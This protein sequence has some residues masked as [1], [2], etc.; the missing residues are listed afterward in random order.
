MFTDNYLAAK[1]NYY[2][3]FIQILILILLLLPLYWRSR[4]VS[5]FIKCWKKGKI[6][7]AKFESA[8]HLYDYYRNSIGR[9]LAVYKYQVGE[10]SF[11]LK[12]TYTHAMYIHILNQSP[13]L[14]VPVIVKLTVT[15]ILTSGGYIPGKKISVAVIPNEIKEKGA[16]YVIPLPFGDE[17]QIMYNPDNPKEAIPLCVLDDEIVAALN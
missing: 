14:L 2:L 7:T 16:S 4:S 3:M 11:E 17:I 8:I 12:L 13:D 15:N 5:R 9:S 1:N 6:S 10:T